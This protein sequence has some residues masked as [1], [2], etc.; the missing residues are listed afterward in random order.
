MGDNYS[1]PDPLFA[2]FNIEFQFNLDACA[3]DW[4]HK[5]NNY[6]T[7]QDDALT[8][9]WE[10][11]VWMNPPYSN[12]GTWIKKAYEECQKGSTI[13]CL[14]PARVETNWFHDYCTGHE[15]RFIKGRVHYADKDGKEG[16]PR[17]G[18]I[19]VIMRPI[20]YDSGTRSVTQPKGLKI[21]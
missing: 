8:K 14:I 1:T 4:N 19:L 13:V 7:E 20:K 5:C 16:R 12:C 17:F 10:G 6:F 9:D 2:Q 3:S 18:N 11:V 15:I 21:N